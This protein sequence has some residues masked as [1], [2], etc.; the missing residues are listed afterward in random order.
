MRKNI[1]SLLSTTVLMLGLSAFQAQAGCNDIAL[2]NHYGSFTGTLCITA[3]NLT[4]DAVAVV[5]ATGKTYTVDVDATI[6]GAPGNCTVA[7]TVTISDGTETITRTFSCGGE[8]SLGASTQ[9]VGKSISM[10]MLQQP[11]P[12]PPP[13][14]VPAPGEFQE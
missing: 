5:T 12:P 13:R 14:F 8:T 1:I 4:L 3:T 6:S 10:V 2:T 9:F 7:G 11:P